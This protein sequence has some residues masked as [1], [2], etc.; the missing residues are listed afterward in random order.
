MRL[1]VIEVLIRTQ[2]HNYYDKTIITRILTGV[3]SAV[4]RSRKKA[5]IPSI[6]GLQH[7]QGSFPLYV[8]LNW[9]FV[10]M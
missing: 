5:G 2:A 3:T 1:A 6:V 7:N 4:L 8:S 10:S 9:I